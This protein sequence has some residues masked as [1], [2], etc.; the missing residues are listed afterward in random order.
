MPSPRTERKILLGRAARKPRARPRAFVTRASG[1]EERPCGTRTRKG[2]IAIAPVQYRTRLL[3]GGG[4]PGPPPTRSVPCPPSTR[5][6][7]RPRER[8]R[9]P[10]ARPSDF[11]VLARRRNRAISR[12]EMA[13]RLTA[14]VP[15]AELTETDSQR[16]AGEPIHGRV[17][18]T[19]PGWGTGVWTDRGERGGWEDVVVVVVVVVVVDAGGAG[20]RTWRR[21]RTSNPSQQRTRRTRTTGRGA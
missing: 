11:H 21:R 14:V 1:R 15:T 7:S 13:A 2:R 3:S 8:L 5:A 10:R 6:T 19:G 18:R 17:S 4:A 12:S 16:F 9:L 20:A